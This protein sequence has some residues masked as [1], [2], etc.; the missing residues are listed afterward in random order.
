MKMKKIISLLVLLLAFLFVAVPQPVHAGPCS[1]AFAKCL[2]NISVSP[3]WKAS[4][5]YVECW[6]DFAACLA[7]KF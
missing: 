5:D 3:W 4:L 7:K 2:D 1:D 6:V